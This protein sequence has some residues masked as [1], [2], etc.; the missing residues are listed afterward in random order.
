MFVVVIALGLVAAWWKARSA[1]TQPLIGRDSG[2][3]LV[4]AVGWGTEFAH[5]ANATCWRSCTVASRPAPRCPPSTRAH[6]C[7]GATDRGSSS[8]RPVRP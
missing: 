5:F 4:G 3:V 8:G 1:Q 2:P 6:A 7:G